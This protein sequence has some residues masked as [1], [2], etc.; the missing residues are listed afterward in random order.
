MPL[1]SG[2]KSVAYPLDPAIATRNRDYVEA[3]RGLRER[4]IRLQEAPRARDQSEL[5]SAIDSLGR[6]SER[7]VSPITDLGNDH[8]LAVAK[9]E[10]DFTL[11]ATEISREHDETFLL[12]KRAGADLGIS[13]VFLARS[14]PQGRGDASMGP[15]AIVAMESAIPCATPL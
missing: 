4:G 15:G 1:L 12:E 11:P 7:I 13:P 8:G 2:A 14:P 10:I 5:F 9:D 3:K 6:R